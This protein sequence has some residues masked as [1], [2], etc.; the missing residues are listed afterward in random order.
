M[1]GILNQYISGCRFHVFT[2]CIRF[3]LVV[4]TAVALLKMTKLRQAC[5]PNRTPPGLLGTSGSHTCDVQR[6]S[7]PQRTLPHV[8]ETRHFPYTVPDFLMLQPQQTAAKQDLGTYAILSVFLFLSVYNWHGCSSITKTKI[9]SFKQV[10]K[11]LNE[12]MNK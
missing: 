7:T 4:H 1:K 6:A 5:L 9:F 12:W 2:P 3:A 8:L 11:Q 10:F